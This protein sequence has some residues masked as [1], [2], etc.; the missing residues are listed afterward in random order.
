MIHGNSVVSV[1]ASMLADTPKYGGR[2][3]STY[4]FNRLHL[5]TFTHIS[6]FIQVCRVNTL[7][8]PHQ[9]LYLSFSSG[10]RYSSSVNLCQNPNSRSKSSL[11]IF[12]IFCVHM[13]KKGE[14]GPN[15]SSFFPLSDVSSDSA[16]RET[17]DPGSGGNDLGLVLAPRLCLSC[18]SHTPSDTG[19]INNRPILSWSM[20]ASRLLPA[21]LVTQDFPVASLKAVQV[22][23]AETQTKRRN[24]I[25]I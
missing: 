6:V 9:T 18:S 12:A 4:I 8:F 14:N 13:V 25:Y 24:L 15:I 7:L 19:R 2:N 3:C 20:A 23:P 22:H 10:L 1:L 17:L 16:W 21:S 5:N 11:G